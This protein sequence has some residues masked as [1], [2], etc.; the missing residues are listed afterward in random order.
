MTIWSAA[1][2]RAWIERHGGNVTAAARR[3]ALG[4]T[5]LQALLDERP[6]AERA[7]RMRLATTRHMQAEAKKL[8]ARRGSAAGAVAAI[9]VAA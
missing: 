5:H 1:E 8:V 2:V 9:R 4:R 7:R 3:L 6:G